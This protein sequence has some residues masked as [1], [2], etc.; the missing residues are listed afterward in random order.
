[1]FIILNMY[2]LIY[3][4]NLN[5]VIYAN[6]MAGNIPSYNLKLDAC[7]QNKT[8][9]KFVRVAMECLISV[10]SRSEKPNPRT[11]ASTSAL[12]ITGPLVAE[13]WAISI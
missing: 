9:L 6:E 12:G 4:F 10:A 7:K 13:S 2:D 3:N 1:M 5:F 8:V 11:W